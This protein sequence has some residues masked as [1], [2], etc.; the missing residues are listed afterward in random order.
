MIEEKVSVCKVVKFFSI[1][2]LYKSDGKTK[3]SGNVALEV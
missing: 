3:M 1:V 2:T